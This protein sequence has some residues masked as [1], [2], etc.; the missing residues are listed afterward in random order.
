VTLLNRPGGN[1]NSGDNFTNTVFDDEATQP[2]AG[3]SSG[4]A[5]FTGSFRPDQALS[6]FDGENQGGV[7]TLKVRDN[8]GSD[9]G[10]INSWS[11]VDG[12]TCS[13]GVAPLPV[14]TT[15]SASGIGQNT[16]TLAGALDAKGTATN[17]AFEYGTT[18]S[19]GSET[20]QAGGGSGNGA[21][22]RS[23]AIS[24][25]TPNTTYHYRVVAYRSGNKIAAGADKTFKTLSTPTTSD[26]CNKAKAAL[27]AAE[28]AAATAL[29]KKKAAKKK[30]QKAKQ[31][32]NA[33]KIKKAKKKYKKAKKR[34]RAA[35]AAV[36]AAQ[37]KVDAVC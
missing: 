33:K 10:T 32:G 23:A 18:S 9:T 8:A 28:D 31:S 2:I 5:P 17:Y 15:G 20:P 6:A 26:D 3:V 16:A 11:L 13:T 24:G 29:A 35:R 25:L 30:V 4:N 37:A 7:W 22:A 34:L 19:Y 14:A 36:D 1:N 27:A 21:V 12:Y